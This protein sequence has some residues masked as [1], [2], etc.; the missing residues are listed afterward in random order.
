MYK[1]VYNKFRD[2]LP[3]A[4]KI[5]LSKAVFKLT[6]KPFYD[7]FNKIELKKGIVIISADFEL[8]WAWRYSKR[9]VDPIKMAKQE[10]EHFPLILNKLNELEIPITWATVGHLFLDSCEKKNG[11]A[12]P[13]IPRPEFFENEFWKYD[14]GDWYD[15]DPCGNYRTHPEFYA[16]DLI[17]MILNSNIKHEIGCHSFSHIDYSEERSSKELIEADLYACEQAAKRFGVKMESF[18]FPGNF[19]GHF[20]VLEKYGYKIIRYKSNDMKEIG[21]PERISKNLFAIHDSLAFDLAEKGWDYN[22]VLWKM[23]KYVA[24]AI[25]KKA[26]AHFWFHPSI[27]REQ[28]NNYFFPFLEYLRNERDN[29]NIDIITMKQSALSL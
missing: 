12:H 20:D 29:G 1:S 14:R 19:H 18:V 24:K 4:Q 21:Y 9:K 3:T 11:A 5:T 26:I 23:K 25:E 27:E 17:E 8:A 7:P 10:R 13:E 15:I 22:Y 16:P 28:I 6:N 2:K